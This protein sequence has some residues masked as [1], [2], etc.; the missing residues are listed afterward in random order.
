MSIK[1]KSLTER[2][3]SP[4][5]MFRVAS[6]APFGCKKEMKIPR[7]AE[8]KIR[9]IIILLLIITIIEFISTF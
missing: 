2:I 7:N 5:T 8:F 6:A 9:T 1:D 3:W 4:S